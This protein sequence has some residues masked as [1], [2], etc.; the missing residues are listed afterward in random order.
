MGFRQLNAESPTDGRRFYPL[1][2]PGVGRIPDFIVY[3]D[4]SNSSNIMAGLSIAANPYGS[5]VVVIHP[6]AVPLLAQPF[7]STKHYPMIGDGR[8]HILSTVGP[9]SVR[10]KRVNLYID[11][12][13]KL[14]RRFDVT[15]AANF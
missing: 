9:I 14:T 10:G 7:S 13:P 11:N 2:A 3:N 12:D 1:S 6:S 4:A 5:L 8:R 15:V